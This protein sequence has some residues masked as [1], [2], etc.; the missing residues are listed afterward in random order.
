MALKPPAPLLRHVKDGRTV[1]FCGSG[2]SAWAK[3]PTWKTLL[4]DMVK[5]A[6][7][8]S[9]D[10]SENAELK[11]LIES[12]KLLEVAD[13]CRE[14]L[15][16]QRY[17]EILTARLRGVDETIPEPHR[18]IAKLPFSG[19]VTTNYD[20]LLERAYASSGGWPKTPTHMDIDSLGPLLFNQSFFILKAHGD[21]DNSKS[22]VLTTRDYQNLIHSNPAF[23]AIF[24]AILMTRA[25]LF[26]GYSLSDPDFRLLMDRQL[27]AFSGNIPPRFA[28]MTGTGKIERDVLWRSARIK[29][30]LY[31]E[32]KHEQVL[33]FLSALLD[34]ILPEGATA[35]GPTSRMAPLPR[36][37]PAATGTTLT[38]RVSGPTLSVACTS[39]GGTYG[40]SS[41]TLPPW[42]VLA[43]LIVKTQGTMQRAKS[44]GQLLTQCI[45]APVLELLAATAEHDVVTLDL[46]AELDVLPW[47]WLQVG[48][49]F[50]VVRNTV[51]RTPT[52][53]SNAS[54][55]YPVVHDSA[56]VLLIGDPRND[57][58]PTL[59]CA[60][61][62]TREIRDAWAKRPEATC[63]VLEG[64]SATYDNV[65]E[66]ILAGQYDV[67]HFAG[68][69][70]VDEEPFLFLAE[71]TRLHASELRSLLSPHPPAI[72]FL[73]SHYTI[74]MPYGSSGEQAK[75][76]AKT[77][78]ATPPSGHRG[79]LDATS[80]AGVGALVG[81]FS[82][83]LEDLVA[84]KVAVNFHNFL[85]QG[86][87]VAKSLHR[88]IM[89]A[90]PPEKDLE[91]G[92]LSYAISGY[93][94]LKLPLRSDRQLPK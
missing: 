54:R 41:Q 45:P 38:L 77:E 81:N 89:A 80:T 11:G 17:H 13:H 76:A 78:G 73:N 21:I 33:D 2:L 6:S 44:I 42:N 34:G 31:D 62:E 82:G 58:M 1:L 48:N 72:L 36:S 3:L 50:L 49:Q 90:E 22:M 15:G 71:G 39:P 86:V 59:P 4:T 14:V 92:R 57:D 10:E 93:G 37:V 46:S 30:L 20:K 69:A 47:E 35:E 74:F 64:T 75:E 23:N 28:L 26:V 70:W 5:E 19:I 79:F 66:E 8:E 85:L 29:V 56:R 67:V 68:H 24:S 32:G 55:G 87:S 65:A 12:G 18:I 16:P 94:D 84:Q 83:G 9:A 88:A 43:K 91:G 7:A 27:T 25:I 53:V 61:A 51:L 60:L 40:G 52:G 63:K